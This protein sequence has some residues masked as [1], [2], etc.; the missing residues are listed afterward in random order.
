MSKKLNN[1]ILTTA[2]IT[3]IAVSMTITG[4][5]A[6]FVSRDMAENGFTVGNNEISLHET[7]RNPDIVPGQVTEI[8]KKVDVTNTGINYAAIRIRVEY[9][10]SVLMAENGGKVSADYDTVHWTKVGNYW[11]YNEPVAPDQSTEY[12]L[13]NKVT[14]TNPTE[15]EAR[16]FNVYVYAESRDCDED[17]ASSSFPALFDKGYTGGPDPATNGGQG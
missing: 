11:Y 2:L 9:S 4:I 15:E 6:Y 7:F 16:D 10:D 12:S 13:F 17:T 5:M 1:T 8:T 3:I 14:V